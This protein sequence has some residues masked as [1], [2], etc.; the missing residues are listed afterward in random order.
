MLKLD[1]PLQQA[2]EQ[3]RLGQVI[4]YPTE[5]VYG[6]GCDPFNQEALLR[7]LALKQRALEKG[8]IL[9]GASLEQVSPFIHWS[10]LSQARQKQIHQT[11]PGAVTWVLPATEQVP[12]WI[13]GGRT[14][15][16]I[17]V[18]AHPL[19]QQLCQAWGQVLVSTSANQSGQ[20]PALSCEAVGQS[21]PQLLCLKG[22]LLT[23][24]QPSSIIDALTGQKI[25]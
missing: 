13:T 17:R 14:T 7:L 6:L 18:S 10:A 24:N 21:F 4:A 8:V 25:R 19:V 15:V 2:V 12:S 23:P 11:W 16:A 3:L 5:G 9:I 20:A 22:E 1:L